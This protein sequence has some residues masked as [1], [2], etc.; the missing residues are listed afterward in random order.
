MNTSHDS[1]IQLT[2]NHSL[3][4]YLVS[5][6][7]IINFTISEILK[8]YSETEIPQHLIP[9]IIP[10]LKVLQTI[11]TVINTPILINSAYRNPSHNQL[12]EGKPNSLHLIFNAI[13]F[14]VPAYDH[15][16]LQHLFTL[17]KSRN[18]VTLCHFNE[19]NYT[20]TPNLMGIGLYQSFIHIDTRGLL[21]RPSPAE[22]YG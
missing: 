13:D 22:W 16:T 5:K 19:I 18:F 1:S 12:V 9:N 10:T 2:N 17:I 11:R 21:A 14:S 20:L 7:N 8:K 4:S 6:N 15:S 3:L